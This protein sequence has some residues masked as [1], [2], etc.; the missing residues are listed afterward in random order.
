[1]KLIHK[2]LTVACLS[3]AALVL[4]LAQADDAPP[5]VQA[6]LDNLQRQTSAKPAYDSL[7]VD[8]GNV[9]II[10]LTLTKEAKDN[11]PGL[12][13]KTAQLD[14]TGITDQGNSLWQIGKSTF[15]NTSVQMTGK[16]AA[17]SAT[18]PAASKA[19]PASQ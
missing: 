11:D 12:S 1:M 17:L 2:I 10:N 14:F 15:T 16:D 19:Q 18:I 3:S 6:F 13:V 4:G 7:K 9:T 8:G 5:A